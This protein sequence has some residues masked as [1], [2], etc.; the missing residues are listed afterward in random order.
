MLQ[1]KALR[2]TVILTSWIWATYSAAYCDLPSGPPPPPVTLIKN[3]P[4]TTKLN[5]APIGG[6]M[7]SFTITVAHA[8]TGGWSWCTQSGPNGEW[9]VTAP[10]TN[11]NPIDNGLFD[12][13]VPGVAIRIK[14][15][16]AYG[17]IPLP[18]FTYPTPKDGA[19]LS[20]I[21]KFTFDFIRTGMGIGK[22]DIIPFDYKTTFFIDTSY[23]TPR[24]A[25]YHIE[26]TNLHTKLEHNAFF[27][28]C[29]TPKASTEIDM[30]TI[31]TG[32]VKQGAAPDVPFALNVVCEGL[33]P[34]IKPPVK[35]YF[36]GNAV[37]DGLLNLSGTGQQAVA[38]GVGISLTNDKGV[39]LPFSKSKALPLVWQASGPGSEMYRFSAKAR[40]VPTSGKITAGK[41]DATLTYIL[42]YN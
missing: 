41:A 30:G 35:V 28:T 23:T 12:T 16:R 21:T 39:A 6:V 32:H 17:T 37:R 24:R 20:F 26:G 19:T 36:E 29:Y 40:Y 25:V 13:G 22:G 3:F 34:T 31:Y 7:A 4:A 9:G 1:H 18:P 42:E 27:T 5:P 38:K 8:S 15:E 2:G 10:V 14:P 11:L 33:N